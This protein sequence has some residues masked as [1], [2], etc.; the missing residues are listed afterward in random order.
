MENNQP[1]GLTP[2]QQP[3]PPVDSSSLFHN[4]NGL[5]EQNGEGSPPKNYALVKEAGVPPEKTEGDISEELNRQ[6]EDIIKTY[7]S[8]T[9]L[10]EES[11][12]KGTEKPEK[13]PEKPEKTESLDHPEDGE[14]EDANDES[15]R[16]ASGTKEPGSIK[17]QKLEKKILKGLG[18][19]ATLLMQT[20]NKLNT[21]EE[22]LEVLFKKYAEMVSI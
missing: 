7:G 3:T 16:E 11:P 1:T 9:G 13:K 21:S 12:I 15:E 5:Q 14:N 10:V 20:L 19:E 8:A 17:E 2:K 6:L 4:Q 22:K 18:K